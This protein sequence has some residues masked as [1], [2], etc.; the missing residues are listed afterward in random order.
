MAFQSRSLKKAET[1]QAI[2]DKHGETI[3]D[4]TTG[5]AK[6]KYLF[7]KTQITPEVPVVEVT[8]DLII[9]DINTVHYRNRAYSSIT[10]DKK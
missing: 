8:C 6:Y 4:E 3:T 10:K 9:E 7:K 1:M 5:T 2:H